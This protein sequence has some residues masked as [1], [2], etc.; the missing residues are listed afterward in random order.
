MRKFL[1]FIFFLFVSILAF[2]QDVKNALLIANGEYEGSIKAL[3]KPI[4]DARG[5][6]L[7]LESIGFNVSIVENA[8][9]EQM[10]EALRAFRE[11]C[12]KE[13]GIAFFHYGGH[14]VQLNGINYL[15]PSNTQ[16][17]GI[18]DVP[19]N[20][21]NVNDVMDNMKGDANVI[22]LDACRNNPFG[23]SIGE[24][25]PTRGLAA[26]KNR[27][28]NSITVYSAHIDEI[29]FDGVFTPILTQYI[30]EENTS[31]DEVLQKVSVE[32]VKKTDNKHESVYSSRLKYPIYLSGKADDSVV[33]KTSKSFLEIST[34]TPC[35]L[36]VDIIDMGEIKG[37]STKR[38][39]IPSGNHR[40]KVKY[41]DGNVEI[42]NIMVDSK[43]GEKWKLT[44]LS[45][46]QLEACVVLADQ[47]RLGKDGKEKN[48]KKAFEYYKM[49]ANAGS[50]KGECGVGLC[51]EAGFDVEQNG[52]LQNE[53]IALQWY[54]EASAKGHGEAMYR[55]KQS[56]G[57]RRQLHQSI[58]KKWLKNLTKA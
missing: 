25:I 40:I 51:F 54:E 5:L 8:N 31:L 27:V 47:Y 14:A 52:L 58:V 48:L 43:V 6:K 2:S 13:E 32:V 33:R 38:F 18:K 1:F 23:L 26:I 21:L 11:K 10:Y 53:V 3:D 42:S 36:Y 4:P 50:S 15:L 7:A 56:S 17:A 44:Y 16:L 45:K 24:G 19:R 49:A 41:K 57:M 12:E 9:K 20:S 28:V 30:K 34:Y 46:E 55:K 39:D 35:S 22:I 29:A 37:F